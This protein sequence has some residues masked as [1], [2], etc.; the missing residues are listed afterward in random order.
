M[1]PLFV[2]MLTTMLSVLLKGVQI[3]LSKTAADLRN[4][5]C[6]NVLRPLL[7]SCPNSL[8]FTLLFIVLG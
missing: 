3:A 2:C 5:V 7:N 4:C 6:D 8:T 1:G